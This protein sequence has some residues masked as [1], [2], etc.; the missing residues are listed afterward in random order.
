MN[1]GSDVMYFR[2]AGRHPQIPLSFFFLPWIDG[3]A[4]YINCMASCVNYLLDRIVELSGLDGHQLP[5]ISC[6]DGRVGEG[7]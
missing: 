4:L 5:S 2:Y 3:T 1:T 7:T 6:N